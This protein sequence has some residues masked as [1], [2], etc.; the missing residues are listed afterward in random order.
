MNTLIELAGILL[1][2][3]GAALLITSALTVGKRRQRCYDRYTTQ[4]EGQAAAA[5]IKAPKWPA[6]LVVLGLAAILVSK[7]FVI[8]PSGYTGV[9]TTF[10]LIDQESCMSGFNIVV[11]GVQTISLVNNK[12]QDLHF[13]ETFGGETNN[14]TIVNMSDTYVTYQINAADSAWIYANVENW[15]EQLVDAKLV[16]SSVKAASQQLDTSEVTNRAKI[17]PLAKKEMQAHLDDKYGS[18]RVIVKDVIIGNIMF[19]ASYE[20]AIAK[21]TAAEQEQQEQAIRNKIDIEK[22][23]AK[24]EAEKQLAEGEAQAELI[25]ARAKAEA[26]SIISASVTEA[27]Q[28]QD[29]IEKWDGALPKAS[30]DDVSF[31]ILDLSTNGSAANNKPASTPSNIVPGSTTVEVS[32]GTP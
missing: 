6:V 20:Q 19:E 13:E 27:T 24:A 14:G 21:R 1:L 10:G 18:D 29:A 17:E 3:A 26:N 31:G 2:F 9:R 16:G 23:Q 12:Q 22:A 30:G 8:V 15:V 11:P 5:K 7:S 28:L 4:E 32:P 25:R